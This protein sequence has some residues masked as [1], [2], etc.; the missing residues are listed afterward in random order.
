M[1]S[2]QSGGGGG[3]N[4][5]RPS[6]WC[7]LYCQRSG[8]IWCFCCHGRT[9][10]TL[11]MAATC[12]SETVPSPNRIVL[13]LLKDS[14]VHVIPIPLVRKNS[15]NHV[16]LSFAVVRVW[17]NSRLPFFKI[18]RRAG[19]WA[20]FQIVCV[21]FLL[22][23]ITT[24]MHIS[25]RLATAAP[26][27]P[28]KCSL[29]SWHFLLVYPNIVSSFCNPLKQ[30][31][32]AK[33]YINLYEYLL[34]CFGDT[35]I[36]NSVRRPACSAW[37]VCQ[38]ASCALTFLA[39]CASVTFTKQTATVQQLEALFHTSA[40]ASSSLCHCA[41]LRKETRFRHVCRS[42]CR[43]VCVECLGTR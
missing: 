41:K 17:R 20:E 5:L 18:P 38:T 32:F 29:P 19:K 34:K 9:R 35:H 37:P 28:S 43:S 2:Q 21:P 27:L 23:S 30:E 11:K 15:R 7:G 8:I 1:N 26:F 3:G 39:F 40:A 4:E 33:Q 22:F 24:K 12:F 6:C 42:V 16:M 31:S 14:C 25:H 10:Y 13:K 36:T